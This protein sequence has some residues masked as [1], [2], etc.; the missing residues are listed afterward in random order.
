M[1]SV[2]DHKR[3]FM[4]LLSMFG[5]KVLSYLV[6]GGCLLAGPS[7]ALAKERPHKERHHM[8]NHDAFRGG[9]ADRLNSKESAFGER[10]H[11][12]H[13]RGKHMKGKGLHKKHGHKKGD[14][15]KHGHKGHAHKHG[16]KPKAA[17]PAK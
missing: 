14:H 11:K 8:R 6:I 17:A 7:W 5:S 1:S 13:M 10:S 3:N 4:K 9:K 16:E 15:K 2:L 12:K